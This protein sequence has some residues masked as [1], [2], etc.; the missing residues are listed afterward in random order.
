MNSGRESAAG[1]GKHTRPLVGHPKLT[2]EA[3]RA[4]LGK[5]YRRERRLRF[6]SVSAVVLALSFLLFLFVDI[7][8]KGWSGFLQTVVAID[9]TFDPAIVDPA[10]TRDPA[11]LAGAD[12][13]E[14]WRGPLKARFPVSGREERRE[15]YGLMAEAA[16][17]DLRD[18][19][20][21]D[22][23]LI[24]QTRRVELPVSSE[25]DLVFKGKVPRT[26]E[27]G[28][29]LTERQ[30]GWMGELEKEEALRRRFN[31]T[32]FTSGDSRDPVQAGLLAA[33]IGSFYAILV[34]V[35]VAFPLGVAT[36]IYLEEFAPKNN[37]WIDLIEVN[38]NN[39]AAVPSIVFGLL[40]LAVF[41][42]VF[43]LPRSSPL[44]GGLILSLMTL[45]VIII[46]ARVAIQS[47]PP[48]IRQAAYAVGATPLQ[49]IQ[50][51]VLPMAMPGILT[52]T[53]I[54]IARAVGETAPLL[55]IGMVAFI[56]DIPTTP[57]DPATALPVQIFLW[58]D[59]PE[60][61]FVEKT[62]AAILVLL[63]FLITMNSF[64][65]LLR[66]RWQRRF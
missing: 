42:N 20:L 14:L 11:T 10:G 38:V 43:G 6:Y 33:V 64:A 8:R 56:V 59:S 49:V 13:A 36:A 31:R 47:V 24:G 32:F 7:V 51:H 41:L 1:N 21:A 30:A 18:M 45:P 60:R 23:D 9:V 61:G 63:A 16:T 62:S 46:A 12:Y 39:L 35:L 25:V 48:S 66:R 37:R 27:L 4:R 28:G 55:M 53:I 34:T 50:H 29:R 57:V 2:D 22:P 5:R 40:G 44:A 15:L 65:V 19:V 3:V 58:A 26:M 54:G 52:G 17:Y